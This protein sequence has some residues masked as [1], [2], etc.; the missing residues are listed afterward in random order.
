MVSRTPIAG[1][2]N[3]KR[4]RIAITTRRLAPRIDGLPMTSPHRLKEAVA[5]TR[6]STE[7]QGQSGVGLE[8]QQAAIRKAAEL[9]GFQIQEWYSDIGSG[10]HV[11][12]LAKR[13]GVRQAIQH[14]MSRRIP[15]LVEGLSR[16]SRDAETVEQLVRD[17]R[18][19][20]ICAK[21]GSMADPVVLASRAA[22]AQH[23]GDLISQKTKSA[24]KALKDNG[25]RLGNPTNLAEAQRLGGQANKQ[26]SLDFIR[27]LADALISLGASGMTAPQIVRVLNDNK[28]PTSRG[29]LWTVATLYPV[30]RKIRAL[31][32]TTD[33]SV[34]P[35]ACSIEGEDNHDLRRD[36]NFGRF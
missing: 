27:N 30:L 32:Q 17:T 23:E 14:A 29:N 31:G 33:D 34:T 25:V 36:P 1:L 8:G 28:I 16:F 18:I 12:S 13:D 21:E 11:D 6:V 4:D 10:R 26:R 35:A 15:I 7:K 3:S 22:R 5:Y 9:L 19:E 2:Q 20:I 24:L